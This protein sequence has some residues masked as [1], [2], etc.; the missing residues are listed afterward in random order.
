M[1][2]TTL[3]SPQGIIKDATYLLAKVCDLLE[4]SAP[5]IYTSSDIIMEANDYFKNIEESE[6][7]S[8]KELETI[9]N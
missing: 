4:Q 6:M 8:E 9:F 1:S 7:F 5:E 2:K 3:K